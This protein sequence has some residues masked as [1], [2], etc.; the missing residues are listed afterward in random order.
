MR[1]RRGRRGR[2][3]P[4]GRRG[5]GG[6]RRGRGKGEEGEGGGGRG[7]GGRGRRGGEGGGGRGDMRGRRGRRGR[8]YPLGTARG[9]VDRGRGR[10]GGG[11]E[12]CGG[13]GAVVPA[14]AA[15]AGGGGDGGG[16]EGEG[17]GGGRRGGGRRGG[18]AAT[19]ASA[20]CRPVPSGLPGR[21]RGRHWGRGLS[22]CTPP[23]RLLG[24]GQDEYR[25]GYPRFLLLR[26]RRSVIHRITGLP[27]HPP[28]SLIPRA[29][30]PLGHLS[31]PPRV[32]SCW[33]RG[34]ASSTG[35]R[36]PQGPEP[37]FRCCRWRWQ[38]QAWCTPPYSLRLVQ[39]RE[40]GQG[41]R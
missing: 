12:T 20:A 8:L 41:E 22:S 26:R 17:G 37:S 11:R 40:K 14:G 38:S 5:E 27:P 25:R 19:A 10:R 39:Q 28:A 3:Y 35:S 7:E 9:G 32:R 4:L 29:P 30:L 21:R 36:G 15:G 24:A 33:A 23:P 6:G 16:G 1:G 31:P 18:A 13:G 2:L 34:A